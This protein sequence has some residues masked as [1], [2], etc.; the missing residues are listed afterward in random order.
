MRLTALQSPVLAVLC[1][2]DAPLWA[3]WLTPCVCTR[4]SGWLLR[5]HQ[6]QRLEG[7]ARFRLEEVAALQ[8]GQ[9]RGGRMA[10]LACW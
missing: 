4:R 9:G 7:L 3:C 1:G 10:C 6:S 2:P 8:V 5:L